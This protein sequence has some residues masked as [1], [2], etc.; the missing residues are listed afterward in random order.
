M[1][2][3]APGSRPGE[4]VSSG[5]EGGSRYYII[6][7]LNV[8]YVFQT[9][10]LKLLMEQPGDVDGRMFPRRTIAT[11][12]GFLL[13]ECDAVQASDEVW[14][15]DVTAWRPRINGWKSKQQ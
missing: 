9:A 8:I 12:Q 7:D 2:R 13:P 3:H 15:P 5:I 14:R 10:V 6:G 4:Y 11:S 1:A